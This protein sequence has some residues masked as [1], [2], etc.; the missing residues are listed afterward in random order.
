MIIIKYYK[1]SCNI[2]TNKHLNN[3]YLISLYAF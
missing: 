2:N 3:N 1:K